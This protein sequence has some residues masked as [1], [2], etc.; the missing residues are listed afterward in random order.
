MWL[1]RRFSRISSDPRVAL[2]LSS[3]TGW[4]LAYYLW[5]RMTLPF[6]NPML[7]VGPLALMGFN[8]ANNWARFLAAIFLPA[9]GFLLLTKRRS[10][11]VL[12]TP[13]LTLDNGLAIV[14][15]LEATILIAFAMAVLSFPIPT[16]ALDFF[17]EGETLVPAFN[18]VS[19]KGVW[20]GS[21]FL[22]GATYDVFSSWL[23]WKVFGVNSVGAARLSIQ[24]LRIAKHLAA[25]LFLFILSRKS[26][27]S[28]DS[29]KATILLLFLVACFITGEHRAFFFDRRDLPVFI[30]IS[31]FLLALKQ[32]NVFAFIS[33]LCSAG[34]F[35]YTIERGAYYNA[36][37]V[38][39]Q[40]L[41]IVTA[42]DRTRY[43]RIAGYWTAGALASWFLF[44][45]VAG[46]S[47]FKCFFVTTLSIYQTKDLIDSFVYPRLFQSISYTLPILL[48]SLQVS[49]CLGAWKCGEPR[50]DPQAWTIRLLL[51][52]LGFFYFRSALARS[53]LAHLWYGSGFAYL[54][55]CWVAGNNFCDLAHQSSLRLRLKRRV[56]VLSMISLLL[57]AYSLVALNMGSRLHGLPS[58]LAFLRQSKKMLTKPDTDFLHEDERHVLEFY[59]K[60]TKDE[61]CALVYS[62]VEMAWPYLLRKPSCSRYFN[63]LFA[64]PNVHR[65]AFK[66]DLL[67]RGPRHLLLY[68]SHRTRGADGIPLSRAFSD[69][70]KLIDRYYPER[71]MF[72][73]WVFA[74]RSDRIGSHPR[75]N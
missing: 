72:K 21:Y 30:G 61:P 20:T 71:I 51:T 45:S 73:G 33:G 25:V 23:G 4:S 41:S 55:A 18:F 12:P 38:L 52:S 27:T 5:P 56:L 3:S 49:W 40:I 15:V 10:F 46:V 47:E 42:S 26:A 44:L 11:P 50:R 14:R 70:E 34:T 65:E 57:G 13:N 32:R 69:I 75:D 37:L 68:S 67:A 66:K 63:L 31:F 62:Y 53:D 28:Q 19:G 1:L 17:H 64:S 22:H 39:T 74:R 8:P 58:A 59:R 7:A 35:L 36:A 29:S 6:S 60:L 54:G 24:I 9:V 43:I 16:R 48:I 2:F